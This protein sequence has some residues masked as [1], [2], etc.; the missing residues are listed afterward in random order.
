MRKKLFTD[1]YYME[2]TELENIEHGHLV[3]SE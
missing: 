2:Y 1:A 3:I